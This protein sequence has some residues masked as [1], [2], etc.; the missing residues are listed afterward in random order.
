[1]RRDKNAKHYLILFILLL[2]LVFCF[3]NTAFADQEQVF[4]NTDTSSETAIYAETFSFFYRHC[5]LKRFYCNQINTAYRDLCPD[6]RQIFANRAA[7]TSAQ[8]MLFHG[9]NRSISP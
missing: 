8:H 2:E 4:H 5:A 7:E 6:L 9:K 1:M 3:S